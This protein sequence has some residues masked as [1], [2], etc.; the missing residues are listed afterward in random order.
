MACAYRPTA[1]ERNLDALRSAGE[2]ATTPRI[3]YDLSRQ[4]GRTI[5]WYPV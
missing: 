3:G 5:V 2:A 1:V 4:N